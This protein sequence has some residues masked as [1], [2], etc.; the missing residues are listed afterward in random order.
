MRRNS[1]AFT[2]AEM[3]VVM[4]ILTVMLAAF[5]PIMT[6]R[7]TVDIENPWRWAANNSDI[8]YGLANSQTAMIGTKTKAE[9][10]NAKLVIQIPNSSTDHIVL[11]NEN[12]AAFPL[13]AAGSSIFLGEVSESRTE[14]SGF[15]NSHGSSALES[16]TSGSGNNAFGAFALWK[17]TTGGSNTA[18][19]HTSLGDNTTGS[20]NSA[21]GYWSLDNNTTGRY[22][23]GVG[24]SS[25]YANTTGQ[26]NSALGYQSLKYHI[27]SYNTAIG[28]NAMLGVSGS[29]TGEKNTTLGYNSL[30]AN[31]T[32]YN[33]VAIGYEALKANT[34]GYRNVA[35]GDSALASNTTGSGHTAIGRYALYSMKTGL[36]NTATGMYALG[37]ATSGSNNT[38]TGFYSLYYNTTGGNNAAFGD[39]ALMSNTTG[40]YNAGIGVYSLYSNSTG[41]YNSALGNKACYYVTGSNK[42]CIGAGSGPTATDATT[43]NVVY[44]G[45]SSTTGIISGVSAIT[46]YSDER[47]KN[48]KEEYKNGLEQIRNI[49]PKYFT[50]KDDK[51]KTVR[52]GVIAQEVQKVLPEAVEKNGDGYLVVKQERIQYA[53][54]NAVKQ[55]DKIL[56]NLITEVKTIV[57]RISGIDNRVKVLEEENKL[58]KEQINAINKRLEKLEQDD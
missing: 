15:N 58:L 4:L 1:K 14:T 31:T 21:F 16:L 45:S 13:R 24:M 50:Y 18:M 56:Q 43:T 28:A 9:G 19:G 7:K 20:S 40:S 35:V 47:L 48:I 10:E 30:K 37:S 8:Y 46:V 44:L 25:M 26:E 23:T 3:M 6:K 52:V 2:L 22:N 53:L 49:V 42:T 27:G 55:L 17:N 11:N 5:A 54:L 36:Q 34:T 39:R 12:G 33:N 29:S 41:N 51:D 32:G 57:A 38:A